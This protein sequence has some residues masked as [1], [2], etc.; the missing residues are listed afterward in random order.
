[1]AG[2]IALFGLRRHPCSIDIDI[3]AVIFHLASY[4]CSKNNLAKFWK[5]I[6]I[7]SFISSDKTIYSLQISVF[8]NKLAM[9]FCIWLFPL[10]ESVLA[11]QCLVVS[12]ESH[13]H[14][15]TIEQC[16]CILFIMLVCL[17]V[18]VI[19][20]VKRICGEVQT[21]ERWKAGNI[22]NYIQIENCKRLHLSKHI[23]TYIT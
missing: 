23:S 3:A 15:D 7:F 20:V 10:Q 4:L 9:S 6:W 18:C 14:R 19:S 12:P 17:Y 16:K 5:H 8:K 1:M 21:W 2:G 22:C 13:T 11:I